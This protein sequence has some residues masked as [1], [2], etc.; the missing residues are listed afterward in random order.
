[1]R[2][3]AGRLRFEFLEIRVSGFQG[4]GFQGFRV[5]GFRVEGFKD[6]LGFIQGCKITCGCVLR[7]NAG[8]LR[9]DVLEFRV[10]GFPVLG[11]LG[12]RV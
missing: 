4:F 12:F 9:F 5:E 3:T 2:K 1:M 11:V 7:K 6:C 10:S 8:R